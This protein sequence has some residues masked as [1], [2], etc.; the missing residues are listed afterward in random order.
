[1]SLTAAMLIGRSGLTASQ[2][3]DTVQY[4]RHLVNQTQ[5][6]DTSQK[7]YRNPGSDART[8]WDYGVSALDLGLP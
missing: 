7:R 6:R 2:T 3:G 1:M 4:A 8:G 5:L